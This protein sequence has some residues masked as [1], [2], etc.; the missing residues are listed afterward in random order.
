MGHDRSKGAQGSPAYN[1]GCSLISDSVLTLCKPLRRRVTTSIY[2]MKRNPK[3]PLC[4]LEKIRSPHRSIRSLS[5]SP[6][7][8]ERSLISLL[9]TRTRPLVCH[10]Y[11]IDDFWKIKPITMSA[12]LVMYSHILICHTW[13]AKCFH[14]DIHTSYI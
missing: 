2:S 3:I 9:Q 1:L 14:L 5:R 12:T 8:R 13:R 10:F 6:W 7:G 4:F 11:Q